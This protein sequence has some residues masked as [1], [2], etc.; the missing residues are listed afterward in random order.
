MITLDKF[1]RGVDEIIDSK[2]VYKY[3]NVWSPWA[4]PDAWEEVSV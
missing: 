2:P 4:Y 1:V 3:G